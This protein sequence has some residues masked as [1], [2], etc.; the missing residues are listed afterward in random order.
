MPPRVAGAAVLAAVAAACSVPAGAS[1][2]VPAVRVW[3]GP[4][5]L[6]DAAGQVWRPAGAAMDGRRVPIARPL[7]IT[8]SPR[9]YATLADG[10]TR[11][12][13]RLPAPGRYAVTLYLA[14]PR[15]PRAPRRFSVRAPGVR[16]GVDVPVG[17]GL[18]RP[19][20]TAFETVVR[21]PRLMLRF[22]A[23]HG[24]PVV[25]AIEAQRL[26]PVT[27]PAIGTAFDESFD[28][29]AG[30][31]PSDGAWSAVAGSDWGGKQRQSYTTRPEN[32]A[33]DGSG[34]LVITARKERY[35]NPDGHVA[36][37]TSGRLETAFTTTLER[38]TITARVQI[39]DGGGLWPTFWAMGVEPPAWPA[40][41]EVD[42]MEFAGQRTAMLYGFVHGPTHPGSTLPYQNGAVS[43]GRGTFAAA[44]HTYGIATEPG[45]V[46]FLLD[47]R[48]Y[49]SVSRA[50]IPRGAPWLL[51]R[52]YHLVFNLAVGG[53]G[54]A[55]RAGTRFPARL[56]VDHLSIR[57]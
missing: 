41:G 55:V 56:V 43:H 34:R 12:R 22:R 8:A 33:L 16:L 50:D 23:I 28:G 52:P 4:G 32:I 44:M 14:E 27:M 46:Q 45:V 36:G 9:L 49:G 18:Q 42:I 11:A 6:V 54:G 25:A 38:E 5:R 7:Q 51:S 47:G 35:V 40:S 10:I 15:R 19:V 39:P 37:Y 31:L 29:A 13:L 24:R 26:G 17:N 2:A 57:R 48:R 20:H 53:F 1:A 21:E 30:T 3:A